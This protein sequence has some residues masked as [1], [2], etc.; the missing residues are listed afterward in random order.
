MR[1]CPSISLIDTILADRYELNQEVIV[2][3]LLLNGLQ[4]YIIKHQQLAIGLCREMSHLDFPLKLM[5]CD[6]E[7]SWA[8]TLYSIAFGLGFKYILYGVV[9]SKHLSVENAFLRGNYPSR[10]RNK[11]VSR[12]L[13]SVDPT[14]THCRNSSIPMIWSSKT[15]RTTAEKEFF[16]EACSYGLYCGVSFP[17][18][19]SEGEFGMMSLVMDEEKNLAS[20]SLAELALLRDYAFETSLKFL[21]TRPRQ[22]ELKLTPKE[23]ECLTWV[24]AGKSSWEIAKILVCSEATVNFHITNVKTKF[25]VNSRQHAVV[26]AIKLGLLKVY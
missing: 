2:K 16:E 9:P 23:Q 22:G 13:D 24:A 5:D 14:V 17:V 4:E 20:T 6:T 7:E 25:K 12:R 11:Y 3:C 18:H 15:F 21:G 19:G 10:W 26:K 8:S 1:T